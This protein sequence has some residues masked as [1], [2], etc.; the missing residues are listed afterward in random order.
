MGEFDIQDGVLKRYHGS[1]GDVVIPEG[2][3]S[4]EDDTFTG[5]T[6]LTSVTFPDSVTDIGEFA[7]SECTGLTSVSFPNSMTCIR[8]CVF[9]GCTGLTS[10]TFPDSLT[11]IGIEAFEGCTGL[12]SVS[13]PDGLT[14][15]RDYAFDECT[16]LTSVTIPNSVTD[17]G[18]YAFSDTAWLDARRKEDPLVV[19]NGILIDATTCEGDVTIPD[20]VTK[21]NRRAFRS[22][23][24]SVNIPRSVKC[25]DDLAFVQCASLSSI[26]IP[27]SVESI[28]YR[29][30]I[31]CTGLTSIIVR[32]IRF[33]RDTLE[34]LE[35][36][37]EIRPWEVIGTLFRTLDQVPSYDVPKTW[38]VRWTAFRLCPE[39]ERNAAEIRSGFTSLMSFFIDRNDTEV[40]Q[41]ILGSSRFQDDIRR[42]MDECIGYA[43][44]REAYEMQVMLTNFKK[45]KIGYTD[46]TEQLQL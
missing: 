41:E 43:I 20:S 35:Q 33:D 2:V 4:I 3:T 12:T 19:V 45:E 17:I 13:F 10:V 31:G 38:H 11:S 34:E 21:I 15:I 44:E 18:E 27:D 46:A 23:L 14:A 32:S 5:C 9:Q 1:G 42:C 39:D 28:A 29:A 8:D 36:A 40:M 37:W 26:T 7:F 16:G 6:A 22:N 25:I 30:F 24:T